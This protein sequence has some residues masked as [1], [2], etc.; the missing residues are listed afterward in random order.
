MVAINS[1]PQQEVAKGSGHMEL[2]LA[3]PMTCSSLVAKKPWPSYPGGASAIFTSV[4]IILEGWFVLKNRFSEVL[5]S[6]LQVT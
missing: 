2:A 6:F 3:R 4:L 5:V 1:I